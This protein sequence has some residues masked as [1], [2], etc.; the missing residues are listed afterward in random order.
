MGQ[1]CRKEYYMDSVLKHVAYQSEIVRAC[2]MMRCLVWGRPTQAFS[3]D[4]LVYWLFKMSLFV[5]PYLDTD[6]PWIVNM[7]D[8]G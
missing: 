4:L 5:P 8:G 7:P 3:Q 1:D 2:N 6:G